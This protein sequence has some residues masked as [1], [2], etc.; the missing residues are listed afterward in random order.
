[1]IPLIVCFSLFPGRSPDVVCIARHRKPTVSGIES[2]RCPHLG[3]VSPIHKKP[4]PDHL[5]SLR[6]SIGYA[7]CETGTAAIQST[8][9]H[10]AHLR[11]KTGTHAVS[12]IAY[13]SVF[14]RI[15]KCTCV[16]L[17]GLSVAYG[18]TD[19]YYPCSNLGVGISEG[20]FIFDFDSLPLEVARPI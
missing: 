7:L 13:Y 16:R 20:C 4:R 9:S 15:K 8:G 5:I 19:H 1:M 10:F 2:Q 12:Q 3:D 18:I 14:I 11:M 6:S 17:R